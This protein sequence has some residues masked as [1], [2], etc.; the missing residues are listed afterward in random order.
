V[1]AA[2]SPAEA[3]GPGPV[4]AATLA[5][6][7][8]LSE[9]HSALGQCALALA[10]ALDS[11]RSLMAAPAMVK[12]LRATLKELTPDDGGDDFQRLMASLSAPFRDAA[13]A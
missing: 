5:E 2:E 3:A 10:R 1:A 8:A 9:A 7:E 4:E 13:Q 11:G 12:E 6:L